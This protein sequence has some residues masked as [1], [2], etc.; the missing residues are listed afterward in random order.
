MYCIAME[1]LN[2]AEQAIEILNVVL[3]E[4]PIAKLL[5]TN[6]EKSTLSS[7]VLRMPLPHFT[8]HY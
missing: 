2:D 7:N 4:I 6:F 5:G 1:Q 8:C 3:N